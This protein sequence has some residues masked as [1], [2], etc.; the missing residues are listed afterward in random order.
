MRARRTMSDAPN[1]MPGYGVDAERSSTSS[2][3]HTTG[4]PHCCEPSSEP[5]AALDPEL[6]VAVTAMVGEGARFV[7]MGGFAVIASRF[8]RAGRYEAAPTPTCPCG[9]PNSASRSGNGS[10]GKA[11]GPS[12]PLPFHKP[13]SS[14]S[15]AT[16][17]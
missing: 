10:G 8:V 5:M 14:S 13:A 9:E 11:S 15:S 2:A 12:T 1:A 3:R 17:G 6:D 7:A 4:R 16:T